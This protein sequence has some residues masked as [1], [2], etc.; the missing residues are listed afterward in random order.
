[1]GCEYYV[2]LLFEEKMSVFKIFKECYKVLVIFVGD[3]INDVL[4]LVSVDVGIGM[5]KGL[6]LSK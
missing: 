6:E 3:G 5:G 1:M 4:I 2:S